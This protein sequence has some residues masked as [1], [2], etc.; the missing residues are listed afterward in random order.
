GS[1]QRT[2]YTVI[3]DSVNLTSRIESLS[4]FYGVSLLVSESAALRLDS[5]WILKKVDRVRVKGKKRAVALF[6][7]YLLSTLS[8]SEITAI[9]GINAIMELYYRGCFSDALALLEQFSQ[10]QTAHLD[11]IKSRCELFVR[12]PPPLWEGVFTMEVK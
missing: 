1:E 4:R 5:S 3:G 12:E 7:P 6:R 8:T 9:E 2:E 11:L 10:P